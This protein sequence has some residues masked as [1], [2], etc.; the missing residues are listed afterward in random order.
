MR[1]ALAAVALFAATFVA[2]RASADP[3]ID[4]T[5]LAAADK[6][7]GYA[8]SP[9][10][11]HAAVLINKGTRFAVSIDGTEGPKVDGLLN[12][13]GSPYNTGVD[14]TLS[15]PIP[16]IFSDDGAH[17]AYIG[18]SG[19]EFFLVSD[20]KEIYRTK[21]SSGL[22]FFV[23]LTVT[24]KHVFFGSPMPSGRYAII[25]DGTP[26]PDSHLQPKLVVS[27]DGN[28]YAYVGTQADGHDTPWAVVD[29]K[30]VK[31][32]GDDLQFT[33]K[34][35]LI[36]ILKEGAASTLN[37]D[38]KAVLRAANIQKVWTSPGGGL[39]AAWISPQPSAPLVL[40]INGKIVPATERVTITHI[41]F[42][43]DDKHF[44]VLVSGN[45]QYI[46][47]DG[48]K[49]DLYQ[50]IPDSTMGVPGSN[51]RAWAHG[52]P[53]GTEVGLEASAPPVPAFTADSSRF[54]YVAMNGQKFVLVSNTDESDPLPNLF[55]PEMS[56]DGNH[57]AYVVNLPG[58]PPAVVIDDK[59]L[60]LTQAN[61]GTGAEVVFSPD[62]KHTFISAGSG[63]LYL[64]GKYQP[65]LMGNGLAT[66]SPDS[67]HLLF[68]GHEPKK[69][70]PT[71]FL[72]GKPLASGG[73]ANVFHPL[74]SSD[75]KHLFW[76]GHRATTTTNDFDNGVLWVDGKA[77]TV[78][79]NPADVQHT[80][81]WDT[82]PDG[83]L[84]F[85]ARTGEDLHKY[86]V[87]P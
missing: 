80:G 64:D 74:F 39:I 67:Q 34:G 83:S 38:N 32:F 65:D 13:D 78:N 85:V 53:A 45:P 50:M 42:S 31:H 15:R 66:Y 27:P 22:G 87:T 41:Y 60:K 76:V 59:N 71:L 23:P 17:E 21:Y 73:D 46:I 7:A 14:H 86:H 54:L 81:A 20:G 35:H 36:G 69:D 84:T 33:S 68:L 26:G 44:A 8:V 72:D 2:A 10:G 55:T 9:H 37:V 58:K 28:H 3:K 19:D 56:P 82:A 6:L 61:P 11:V 1:P 40:T 79:F 5:P 51:S 25:A 57:Y 18:R 16:V 29:G 24:D 63:Q 77:T 49:G 43:P 70:T 75:S 48:K 52:I 30:Q 12:A 62:G 47:L 4:D